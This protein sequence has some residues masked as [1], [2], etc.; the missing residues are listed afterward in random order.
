M[1]LILL[2]IACSWSASGQYLNVNREELEVIN[3][4][5]SVLKMDRDRYVLSPFV[6]SD[7]D[8]TDLNTKELT[9]KYGFNFKKHNDSKKDTLILNSNENF[10]VINPD[11]LIK[12]QSVESE[13]TQLNLDP[14]LQF[15]ERLYNKTGILYFDKV[16]IS[17]KKDFAL[18]E[19]WMYCGFLCGYGETILMK[20]VNDRWEKLNVLISIIS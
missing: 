17:S 10:I 12:Y 1:F 4:L 15:I 14:K 19:Y 2:I 9:K 13:E 6:R 16:I 3:D 11:S 5:S 8:L 7:I 18:I 20:K